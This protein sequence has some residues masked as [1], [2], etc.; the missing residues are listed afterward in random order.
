M[1]TDRASKSANTTTS[2]IKRHA[3]LPYTFV[4]HTLQPISTDTRGDRRATL[5]A[6]CWPSEEEGECQRVLRTAMIYFPPDLLWLLLVASEEVANA[7]HFF[8]SCIDEV[9]A[10]ECSV[11]IQTLRQFREL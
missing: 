9:R 1:R 8:F 11:R 4:A 10:G 2:S 7:F 6:H 5:R 3:N